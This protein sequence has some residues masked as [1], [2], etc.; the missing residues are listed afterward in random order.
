MTASLGFSTDQLEK[1][2]AGH[3]AREISQQPAVWR[4]T[5]EIVSEQ[6]EAI[7]AFLRPL[8]ERPGLRVVLTGA[9]TSAFAGE[10]LAPALARSTGRRV[11]AVATTDIV[12]NPGE[13]L[14]ED[15]PTLMVSFARS[16][17]SPES[18]AATEIADRLL[19]ECHHLVLTCDPEGR[20]YG[21]HADADRS[22]ALLMPGT[23]N[24]QGF[25]MT[26]SFTSML[27]AAWLVLGD[28]PVGGTVDRLASAAERVLSNRHDGA[29]ELASAGYERVVYLGSGPLKGLARESALKL[30]ELT[31]GAVVTYFDSPMGFRHG[32]KSVL[33]ERTLVILYVSGDPR[34]RL[35]DLDLLAEV[36]RSMRRPGSV[37]AVT[38]TPEVGTDDH[39]TWLLDGLEGMGDAVLALPFVL[40][41]QMLG[42]Y[43]SLDLGLTP[44]NPF[45]DK[46]VNRVV[47][48]VTIHPLEAGHRARATEADRR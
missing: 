2:G 10:I 36:R 8:L 24:D 3:T 30:L 45:P 29:R 18:V 47:Q 40:V 41:A 22:L 26:S 25:A 19:T 5:G 32:P 11:E 6:R 46:E 39:I 23:A 43:V 9:G 34:T 7:D 13:Y 15:Q 14:A 48:G 38:A 42:L 4:K 31:A 1:W 33:D 27:L 37:V 12:S 28:V 16:G 44:D 21:D 20:L 17:N 35:Y